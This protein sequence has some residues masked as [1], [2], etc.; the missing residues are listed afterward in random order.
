MLLSRVW[1]LGFLSLFSHSTYH[2]RLDNFANFVKE[3]NSL[4]SVAV[5]FKIGFYHQRQVTTL[6]S[7]LFLIIILYLLSQDITPVFPSLG[8]L[9]IYFLF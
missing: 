8:F 9:W 2:Q 6:L 1:K 5:L 4:N 3:L 7:L